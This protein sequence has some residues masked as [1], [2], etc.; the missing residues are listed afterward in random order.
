[1]FGLGPYRPLKD[2]ER[3][4]E[5]GDLRMAVAGARD[6]AHEYGH[7]IPLDIAVKFLPVV[8]AQTPDAYDGWALR[9]L[10]RW[11]TESPKRTIE[12]AAVL[13]AALADLGSEPVASWKT[14]TG[15]S[16]G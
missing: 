9:W 10:A 15:L 5:R 8:V 2:V 1:M 16:R 12:R 3:A 4:L 6:C 11:S 14:I 13:A 7:A